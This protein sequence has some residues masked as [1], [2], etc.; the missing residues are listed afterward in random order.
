MTSY[1]SSYSFSYELLFVLNL[2]L[3][4]FLLVTFT[5]VAYSI[6]ILLIFL[7]IVI[8]C[9]LLYSN[10][11]CQYHR[12]IHFVDGKLIPTT[13]KATLC[14]AESICILIFLANAD[15]CCGSLLIVLTNNRFCY[16]CMAKLYC[17]LSFEDD[18]LVVFD[19][20]IVFCN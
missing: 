17:D 7:D 11:F 6:L 1:F 13:L 20:I 3:V 8:D 9:S 19:L 15:Y 4:I 16:I 10:L 12:L 14:R 18:C 2:S 5:F